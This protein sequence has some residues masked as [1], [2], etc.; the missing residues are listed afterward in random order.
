MWRSRWRCVI[1]PAYSVS[2]LLSINI[3]V[4]Q[5]V[6]YFPNDLR[7]LCLKVRWESPAV[8]LAK[9]LWR[10]KIPLVIL[11]YCV[12]KIISYGRINIECFVLATC[13][14]KKKLLNFN[15]VM[16]KVWWIRHHP[17]EQCFSTFMR[18]RPV[19]FFFIR[20]PGPNKFTRKYLSNF[21]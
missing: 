6:L 12:F 13:L 1:K 8:Q 4:W 11:L 16:E 2:F 15:I 9:F 21:F 19:K 20:R 5:N 3:F 14:H 18:P 10:L 17:V 7:R